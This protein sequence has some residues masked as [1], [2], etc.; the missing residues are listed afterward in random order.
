[1][2]PIGAPRFVQWVTAGSASAWDFVCIQLKAATGTISISVNDGTPRIATSGK[3]TTGLEQI[4]CIVKSVPQLGLATTGHRVLLA[5]ALKFMAF[6]ITLFLLFAGV[7]LADSKFYVDSDWSGTQRGTQSQPWRSLNWSA[8]NS[9]LASGNVTVYFSAREAGSDTDDNYD[10]SGGSGRSTISLDN[11]TNN[12]ANRLTLDGFSFW[13]TNDSKPSWSAYSSPWVALSWSTYGTGS[14]C[15]INAATAQNERHTKINNITVR[16]FRIMN[17]DSDKILS[18][19]GDNCIMEYCDASH[20]GTGGSGPGVLLAPTAD[21]PHEGSSAWTPACNNVTFR[22]NKI[23]DTQGEA[24]YVGGAGLDV[25]E[26]GAGYPSHTNVTVLGNEIYAA[27][28][29]GGQGDAI[30]IKAGMTNVV[31]R[32]NYIHNG[33]FQGADSRAIVAQGNKTETGGIIMTAT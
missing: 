2:D 23:H 20:T 4:A 14:L 13:N 21:G 5:S 10:T 33:P 19:A 1:M 27:G 7:A 22:Y 32:N 18:F 28:R 9:S 3:R 26:S 24:L 17:G 15:Q 6:K 16:G 30:D 11:R 29:Y 12:S 25:V 8:I 31:V